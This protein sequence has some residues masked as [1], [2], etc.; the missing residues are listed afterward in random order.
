[1]TRIGNIRGENTEFVN[2]FWGHRDAGFKVIQT[3]I[4]H[5]LTTLEELLDF[6]KERTQI[7]RDYNKKLEKLNSKIHLG[8][9]ETG[10]LKKSLDKLSLENKHMVKDNSKFIRSVTQSNY[11][12]LSNFYS[13]YYK[14]VSKIQ[15]HIQKIINKENDLFKTLELSKNKYQDECSQIKSLRLLIQTTWGKELEKNEAK[16]NKLMSSNANT[17]RQYQI[18]VTNF[19]DV[20]EIYIRDWSIALKDFYQLEIERI[21]ICKIN[22]FNFCNNI[23]T[24][25]V[26][27]DQS[28]DLAR[29]AFAVVSPPQDLQDFGDTYGTGDKIYSPPSFIDFMNGYDDM[30]SETDFTAA[31][32][33]NPDASQ[34]LARSYSSHSQTT[35]SSPSKQPTTPKTQLPLVKETLEK[36]TLPLPPSN[37]IPITVPHN[38]AI[39]PIRNS[40]NGIDNGGSIYSAQDKTDVFSV[41]DKEKSHKFTNSNGSS[42]YSNPTNYSSSNYSSASGNERNWASPRRKEKQLSHFQEQI[43]LKSK[44]LPSFPNSN[45]NTEETNKNVPIMKD[46]SIDFIAKALEDLN[47]GGDGDVNQYR[48]SV[49][50][51]REQDE[52]RA[53]TAPSTPF[54]KMKT[55]SDYANDRHEIAVRHD[56]IMFASPTRKQNPVNASLDGSPIKGGSKQR[57]KSMLDPIP[58]TQL[59]DYQIGGQMDQL[60]DTCIIRKPSDQFRTPKDKPKR[61]LLKSPTKSYTDLNAMIQQPPKPNVTPVGNTPYISKAKAMYTYRPQDHGELYFKKGWFM[62][63]IYK[64]EDNWFVCELGN[65]CN[66]RDGMIGLVPGNYITEGE[67]LF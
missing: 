56:S 46:F 51:A 62:Y 32:F 65:N 5:A 24:L 50:S 14:K 52:F 37:G 67:G 63:V 10:T 25:C 17:K 59:S 16:L 30:A 12:K 41:M 23:A 40:P 34:L 22:C 9:S 60:V 66:D 38:N 20:H 2:N 11:D 26:D 15:L 43:N 42:N 54:G 27:N 45:Q 44:E 29:S 31:E 19:A 35:Q 3:K 18:A 1:M 53:K 33:K 6:Y 47:S 48:K 55:H 36:A 8:S 39:S 7:E 4:K 64:Q 49:R 28:V 13:I 61:S 58:N 21:Q 57:P